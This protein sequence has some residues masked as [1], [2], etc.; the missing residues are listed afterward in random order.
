[1][2]TPIRKSYQLIN[3]TT[4]NIHICIPRYGAKGGTSITIPPS[5]VY[6]IYPVA[7]SIEMCKAVPALRDLEFRNLIFIKCVE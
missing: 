2:G 7:G 3:R 4:D 1:M 6:D 5:G